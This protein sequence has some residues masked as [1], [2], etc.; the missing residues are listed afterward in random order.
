MSGLNK[1]Y[2]VG[3]GPGEYEQMTVKAVRALERAE[4]IVGYKGYVD[5]IK[6]SFPEKEYCSTAMKG[7]IERCKSALEYCGNGRITAVVCSGDAGV[8]GMASLIYELIESGGDDI[9]VEVIGGVTA[10]MS[11]AALLGAPLTHDFSVISLSDL[12]TPLDLI[13]KRVECAAMSD[14]CI[15]IY[16][17][18]ST[19]RGRYLL[20]M[21]EIIMRHQP[22]TLICGAAKNIGRENEAYEILTLEELAGYEADMFTTV[23]VGNSHTRIINGK[24]VTP[25]GYAEK[26]GVN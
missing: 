16:N 2:V 3:I 8:Y 14:M 22:K 24:M 6:D 5:L 20:R 15:C 11:G 19:K 4:V 26:Y 18:S 10:A 25:R 1:I 9:E 7:E 12:L 13:E 17:P 21:C 23:F